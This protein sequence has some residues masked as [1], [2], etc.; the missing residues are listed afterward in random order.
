MVHDTWALPRAD[1]LAAAAKTYDLL[2]GLSQRP[3]LFANA[4]YGDLGSDGH[5]ALAGTPIETTGL[6]LVAGQVPTAEDLARL[7][8]K[9]VVAG[10]VSGHNI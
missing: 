5:E 10:M 3:A 2:G 6:D 1:V 4:P 9:T 8:D 7:E